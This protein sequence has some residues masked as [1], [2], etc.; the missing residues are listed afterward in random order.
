MTNLR[1][2]EK[3]EKSYLSSPI[4]APLIDGAKFF[5]VEGFFLTH[6]V[7]SVLDV[8]KKSSE[9]GKVR[10]PHHMPS[11]ANLTSTLRRHSQTFAINLSAPFIA[12][13]FQVQLQQVLP[14][15]DLVFGN[16][17]EA[18]AWASAT[19]QPDKSDL[20]AIAQAIAALPKANPSRPRTVIFTHGAKAT[21][22]ASSKESVPRVFNVH[23]LKD[24][25][26]VDTNGAGDAFAGGFVAGLILGKSLEE[27]VEAGHKMGA[28]CV[29][30]VRLILFAFNLT[31]T[32]L[33]LYLSDWTHI[34]MAEDQ[35]PIE[36]IVTDLPIAL[37]SNLYRSHLAFHSFKYRFALP[38]VYVPKWLR[39][40]RHQDSS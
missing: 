12:Q 18:E 39:E 30:Q 34:P 33:H 8:A 28:M 29:R 23:A 24:E 13:F 19:G 16:E 17:A 10:L 1:A 37:N 35:H 11:W 9:A 31:V 40:A 27:C 21:I 2:A 3:F 25:E 32:H 20:G 7:E 26:I 4:I 36:C 38:D 6:G 5:Y 15:C 14:Y 22:V